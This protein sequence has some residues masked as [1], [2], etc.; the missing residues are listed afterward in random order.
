MMQFTNDPV[1]CGHCKSLAPIYEQAAESL[2]G[3]AKFARVDCT[4]QAS[5]CQQYGVR[6]YPTLKIFTDGQASDYNGA[7]SVESL[8]STMKK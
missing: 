1:G 3:V 8:V 4:T 7:R 6:G 2:K 5:I